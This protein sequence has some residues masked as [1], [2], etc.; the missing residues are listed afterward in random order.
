MAEPS[1]YTIS[2]SAHRGRTASAAEVRTLEERV[3]ILEELLESATSG[4]AS[5]SAQVTTRKQRKELNR[6]GRNPNG[7]PSAPPISRKHRTPK[8]HASFRR[9]VYVGYGGLRGGKNIVKQAYPARGAWPK[10]PPSHST[11]TSGPSESQSAEQELTS[12]DQL[13]LH[14]GR[15]YNDPINQNQLRRYFRYM[16]AHRQR[17][18]VPPDMTLEELIAR[19]AVTFD[20]WATEYTR[21]LSSTGQKK[22]EAALARSVETS[23]RERKSVARAKALRI[24]RYYLFSDGAK[25][26]KP[27]EKD[28][29]RQVRQ[30]AVRADVEFAVQKFVMSDEEDEWVPVED[31]GK[32]RAPRR[33]SSDADSDNDGMDEDPS[34]YTARR[35]VGLI[36]RSACLISQLESLDKKRKRQPA[37]ITLPPRRLQDVPP[38]FTLP[39]NIRRWMVARSWAEANPD[40]C[41]DVSDNAGPFEDRFSVV[42]AAKDWG[43]D[44]D[45]SMFSTP[46]QRGNEDGDLSAGDGDILRRSDQ[47]SDEADDPERS[48]DEEDSE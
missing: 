47:D 8:L 28:D 18:G 7:G 17:C 40:A 41:V 1:P 29:A 31:K 33:S 16:L 6:L 32:G 35:R 25:V 38:G 12:G 39:S 11:E 5:Q 3:A 15:P 23:R 26:S 24:D 9:L 2:P 22:K 21:S 10:H 36:W 46:S 13:R 14:L 27:K 19:C 48:D 43:E 4:V 20:G 42:K 37:K 45:W 44:P 30:G 34:G